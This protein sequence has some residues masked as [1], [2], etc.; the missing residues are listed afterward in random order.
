MVIIRT[1]SLA[2]RSRTRRFW[3]ADSRG[4]VDPAGA[5][6]LAPTATN[7]QLGTARSP[8]A[9]WIDVTRLRSRRDGSDRDRWRDAGHLQLVGTA[10]QVL[11][12]RCATARSLQCRAEPRAT[13]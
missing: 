2:D 1:L 5:R 3:V 7:G 10:G 4:G 12:L 6:T 11:I 13:L 9:Q 8:T